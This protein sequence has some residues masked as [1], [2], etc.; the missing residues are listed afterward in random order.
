MADL[1]AGRTKNMQD[2]LEQI[3][4]RKRA[5]VRELDGELVRL[6]QEARG[7]GRRSRS[8]VVA[9]KK[10]ERI[11]LIAEVKRASPS[12]GA[13][14]PGCDPVKQALLYVDAGADGISVLTDGPFFSGSGE[15]LR[16]IREAVDLPILRK[17][18]IL[19]EA[20]LYQS[21]I[22]GADAVLLI[23]AALAKERLYELHSLAI[24]LDL[25]PLVEVHNR[26][27]L[28]R[29]LA[30]DAKLIGINN[31]DLRT[32]SIDL[33]TTEQLIGSIPEGCVVVS[34]SGIVSGRQAADL[35][36][37]G[38]DAILVG[39]ALMQSPNPK[40]KV[41]EFYREGGTKGGWR[42]LGG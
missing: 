8:L 6:R 41:A 25:A 21:V 2:R 36:S 13:I 10:R 33:A 26:A 18:F 17:D 1:G 14:A 12:A 40:E 42:P 7:L 19:S 4:H 24:D 30:I 32:F 16:Q 29:A 38:V 5:E 23:V 39:Q 28:E 11:A 20:Q 15:D 27:E 31:R 35:R 37:V 34:E 3:L 9:L 22:L